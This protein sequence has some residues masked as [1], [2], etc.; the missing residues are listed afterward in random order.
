MTRIDAIFK[1]QLN[2]RD[3]AAELGR[4]AIDLE[5]QNTE[6]LEF[7]SRQSDYIIHQ[8]NQMSILGDALTKAQAERDA[9]KALADTNAA[10]AVTVADLTAKNALPTQAEIDAANAELGAGTAGAPATPAA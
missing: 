1:K 8:E 10:A 2:A 9:A 5:K 4:L 6:L 3:L 7:V